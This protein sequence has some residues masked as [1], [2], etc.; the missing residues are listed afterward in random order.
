MP[1]W[2]NAGATT[3]SSSA[4]A[5]TPA[6]PATTGRWIDAGR[7][8]SAPAAPPS[9]VIPITSTAVPTSGSNPRYSWS[10]VAG[11]IEMKHC[12]DRF[13]TDQVDDAEADRDH[14]AGGQ[15][16]GQAGDQRG[17]RRQRHELAGDHARANGDPAAQGRGQEDQDLVHRETG[18]D[19]R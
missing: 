12:P 9:A 11:E 17:H 18:A 15:A 10:K 14:D 8:R 19:D 7:L 4:M 5:T 6:R 16:G 3:R 2:S 1:V 13:R